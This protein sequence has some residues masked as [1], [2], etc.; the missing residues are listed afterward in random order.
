MRRLTVFAYTPA[1]A[2]SRLHTLTLQDMLWIHFQIARKVTSYEYAKLEEATFYQYAYG[3]STGLAAQA[4]RFAKGFATLAPFDSANEAVGFVGLVAFMVMNG[5]RPTFE[6]G[7]AAVAYASMAAQGSAQAVEAN[8]AL[9]PAAGHVD[10]KGV[11]YGV[12]ARYG[13]AIGSLAA[14]PA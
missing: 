10:V 6:A 1:V 4:G 3:D 14:V 12:L 5:W 8:F 13:E 7:A 2:M 9:D 11:V